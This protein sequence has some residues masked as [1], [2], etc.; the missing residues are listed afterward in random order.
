[1]QQKSGPQDTARLYGIGAVGR[2]RATRR[3]RPRRRTRR[4]A[5]PCRACRPP[6]CSGCST[7][8]RLPKVTYHVTI[9]TLLFWYTQLFL[10]F[11]LFMWNFCMYSKQWNT[12]PTNTLSLNVDAGIICMLKSITCWL[13]VNLGNARDKFS[14]FSHFDFRFFFVCC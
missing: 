10:H 1:M 2:W 3:R 14:H 5:R 11:L 12:R 9:L 7:T 8:T 4:P 13:R 6:P